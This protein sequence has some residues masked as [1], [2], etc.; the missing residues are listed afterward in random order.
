MKRR[1]LTTQDPADD[2]L[3]RSKAEAIPDGEIG[4]TNT[5][6]IVQDMKD[7]LADTQLGIAIAA[8]QIGESKRIFIVSP[9]AF[10]EGADF[11]VCINPVLTKLSRDK[12]DLEEACL[13]IPGLAGTVRRSNKVTLRAFDEK[14]NAFERGASGL[15][16]QIFQHEYD[17]LDGVL[18]TDRA[19]ETHPFVIS[20][21]EKETNEQ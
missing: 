16:A 11:L 14:G 7:T 17:H 8:P 2:T 1:I 18:F 9:R 12:A 3:L 15:L 13:S 5:Q 4:T 10:G 21:D 6:R 20:A 19:T